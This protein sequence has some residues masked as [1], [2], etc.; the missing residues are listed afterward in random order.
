MV[1]KEVI[2]AYIAV[3][4]RLQMSFQA[5]SQKPGGGMHKLILA[6]GF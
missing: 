1:E 2:S 6:P 3:H 5:A 4:R